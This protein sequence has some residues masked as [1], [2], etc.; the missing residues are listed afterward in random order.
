MMRLD[1][2]SPDEL[3]VVVAVMGDGLEQAEDHLE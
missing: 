3:A 2:L 1:R